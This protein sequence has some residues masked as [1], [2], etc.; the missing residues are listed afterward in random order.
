MLNSQKNFIR[1]LD[2]FF[3]LNVASEPDAGFLGVIGIGDTQHV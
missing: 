3:L 2:N 1:T